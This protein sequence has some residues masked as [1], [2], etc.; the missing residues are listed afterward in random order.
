MRR[1]L[2]MAAIAA[3]VAMPAVTRAELTGGPPWAGA[4]TALSVQAAA[5]K[6][7]VVIGIDGDVDVQDF[8]L[9]SPHRIVIDI[10]GAVS[11]LP[12]RLYDRI[13]RGGITNVRAAQFKP[14]VV[15]VVLD[16]DG[17]HGYDITRGSRDVRVSLK[18][19]D[20]FEPWTLGAASG[21]ASA[22]AVAM[23][24]A[25]PVVTPVVAP[26]IPVAPP[27]SLAQQ[28]AGRRITV[29]YHDT[30]IREVLSAFSGYSGRSILPGPIQNVR[31]TAEI[32]DQPWEIAL[33]KILNTNGLAATIDPNSGIITVDTYANLR[34]AAASEPL[35]RQV[36]ALNYAKADELGPTIAALLSAEC[37]QIGA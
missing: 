35:Q 13:V 15:R 34:N 9:D 2:W 3:A 6:A 10:N 25:L 20:V 32:V 36:V 26:A 28:Q 19:S 1:V 29:S 12:A 22:P 37:G 18:T 5:G 17:E 21:L 8:T 16:L 31:V 23:S 27:L 7:E 24:S 33:N 4:V 30:D 14:T 11:K